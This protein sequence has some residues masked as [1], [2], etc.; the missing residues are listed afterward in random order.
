M[1]IFG[2]YLSENYFESHLFELFLLNYFKTMF[3]LWTLK[4][5]FQQHTILLILRAN[6]RY[7]TFN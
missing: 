6:I 5:I 7:N 3:I 2:D 1:S 4:P